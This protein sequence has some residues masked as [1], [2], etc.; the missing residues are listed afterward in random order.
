MK[1]GESTRL[2]AL[3]ALG[4]VVAGCGGDPNKPELGRVQGTVTFNGQPLTHGSVVFVPVAGKGSDT[5]H[6]ASGMIDERG[7]FEL[8]T[9]NTGD[10]AVLGQH[11]ATVESREQNTFVPPKPGEP[12]N[13]VL[14]KSSTPAKYASAESSPLRY[15]VESGRN[16]FA[17]ELKE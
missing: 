17:L 6:I 16:T 7:N 9:F 14:P 1:S 11:I 5:G 3:L 15:T 8:T 10:G 2:A 12:I 13:Y 4:L